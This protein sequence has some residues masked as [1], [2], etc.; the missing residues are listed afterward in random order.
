MSGHGQALTLIHSE[1]PLNYK[2]TRSVSVASFT[3]VEL[4]LTVTKYDMISSQFSCCSHLHYL[5]FLLEIEF[6]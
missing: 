5:L 4:A 6:S 2:V 1:M 3:F